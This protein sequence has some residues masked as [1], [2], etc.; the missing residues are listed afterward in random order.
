M[1]DCIGSAGGRRGWK[2]AGGEGQ[3]AS[4]RMVMEVAEAVE[5]GMGGAFSG[6]GR[7]SRIG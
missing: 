1:A 2:A 4:V 5:V 7:W 6:V 3:R